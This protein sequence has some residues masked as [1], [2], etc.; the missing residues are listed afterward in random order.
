MYVIT[1][2]IFY[3]RCY[4]GRCKMQLIINNPDNLNLDAFCD[5]LKLRISNDIS[6]D[7]FPINEARAQTWEEYLREADVGWRRDAQNQPI[8]PT[9]K[10]II[11]NFFDNLVV[12]KI[13]QSYVIKAN[14]I[15]NV[16][17]TSITWYMLAR[18]INYGTLATPRYQYFD[19]VLNFYAE[20]LEELYEL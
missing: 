14:E 16:P 11:Y 4:T 1:S 3:V 19:D 8:I 13:N 2:L 12:E 18:L 6:R 9:F 5:W 10:S 20:H 15:L 7:S 17:G